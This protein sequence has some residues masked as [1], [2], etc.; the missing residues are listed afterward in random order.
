M[1]ST[2]TA[3]SFATQRTTRPTELPRLTVAWVLTSTTLLAPVDA[4]LTAASRLC[5]VR[6]PQR[7]QRDTRETEPEFLQRSAP[8]DGLGQAFGQFIEFVVHN[9]AFV[10]V[11]SFRLFQGGEMSLRERL[12]VIG[13]LR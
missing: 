10:L 12:E 13:T 11:W 8:R 9:F 5:I 1:G 2:P 3:M 4:L 6:Q 7:G